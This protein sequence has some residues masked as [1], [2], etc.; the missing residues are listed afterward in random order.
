MPQKYSLI[1]SGYTSMD[2]LIKLRSPA[3][4]GFTSLISNADHSAIH[5]GG[6]SPNICYTLNK[7]G[8]PALP[9]MRVGA[10]WNE[11]GYRRYL[12][13]AGIPLEAVVEI[14]GETTSACYILEDDSGNHITLYYPGAMDGKHF[15]PVEDSF[16]K[17][18][19]YG[20]MTVASVEDN[21]HFFEQ[22]RKF[23]VPLILGMKM[24]T[25]AFPR[26]FL[27]EILTYSSIF[28]AN[29][30][31]MEEVISIFGLDSIIGLFEKGRTEVIVITRGRKGSSFFRR[32]EGGIEEG[33]VGICE[34]GGP[35]VD[36]TGAGD[37]YIA[38]FLH[39]YFRGRTIKECC[40]L[41]SVCSS[42]IIEKMGCTANAPTEA[43]LFGRYDEW[44]GSLK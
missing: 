28:F 5:Y 17:D 29:E 33:K 41:G 18:S 32:T 40:E 27:Y 20:L 39:G 10:D 2:R 22:C 4:V 38:G 1:G 11:N 7:L 15:R 31:E 16:F 26:E 9:I 43:E 12:E 36:R 44:K 24:D 13:E 23:E 14:P 42:F 37:S 3:G 34:T 25:D 19:A 30:S 21:R 8:S 6:C 35:V